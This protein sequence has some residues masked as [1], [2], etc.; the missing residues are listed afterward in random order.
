MGK[1]VDIVPL[2]GI[3]FESTIIHGSESIS[4]KNKLLIKIITKK[5][6]RIT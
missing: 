3:T 1:S 5:I 6:R 2:E 4:N